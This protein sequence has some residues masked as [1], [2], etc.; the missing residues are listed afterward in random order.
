[1]EGSRLRLT[2]DDAAGGLEAKGGA[3]AGFTVA[4]EDRQFYPAEAR[5]EGTD[6]VVLWS[7]AVK[8]PRA[9]R[10]GWEDSPRCNLYNAAGLPAAPFRTDDWPSLTEGAR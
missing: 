8:A 1:V 10:Y 7:D 2:F 6:A 3:L 9:A 5:I 4:G